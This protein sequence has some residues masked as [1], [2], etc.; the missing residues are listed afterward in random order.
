MNRSAWDEFD[1]STDPTVMWDCLE[2]NIMLVL[3][4]V[5][6]IRQMT[7]PEYKPDWLSNDIVQL[8]RRRDKMYREARRKKD[9]I[10]WRKAT[11]LRNRVEMEIKIYKRK[12]IKD[13]L[14]QNRHN[15]K[16]FWENI[17]SKGTNVQGLKSEDEV[18]MFYEGGDLDEHINDYFV[19]IGEK[20][21]R[22]IT[23]MNSAELSSSLALGPV[24]IHNDEIGNNLITSDEIISILKYVKIEKS[25]AIS[26]I[27]TKVLVHAFRR[28]IDRVTKMYN[29]SLTQCTFPDKWKK[30]IIVPLAKVTN[31]KTASDMR[32][33]SLL[34]FPGKIMEILVSKRLKSYLEL[35]NILSDKQHGFRKK[36]STLSAIVE[37]LHGV[38]DHHNEA[39][40]TYVIYLDLKKAFDTVSHQILLNKLKTIGLQQKS[41]LWFKNYLENRTQITT[42]NNVSS[43]EKRVSYGVPQGSVLGPTLFIIYINDLSDLI[44]S[45]INL[46]ADDTIVYG[47]NPLLVQSDME[48]VYN[49]CNTNLLTINCKK[50]QWMK[51]TLRAKSQNNALFFL[52][53]EKLEEVAEYKYLGVLIDSQLTFQA[54]GD[55]LINRVN[56]KVNYFRKIRTYMTLDSAILLYKCTIL[57]VLEYADFVHDFN[58]KYISKK[59]QTIQ[60]SSLYIVFNQYWLAHDLKDS[61]ETIHRR[62]SIYRLIHRIWMHMLLFVYNYSKNP[63]LLDNRDINTR[64]RDGILFDIPVINHYKA[65]QDP[66]H[67]A[68]NAWNSLPVHIRNAETKEKLKVL[69]M[70]SIN[71]P[72]EKTE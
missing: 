47:N 12:K 10:L 48:K 26:N 6:P 44:R 65:R 9:A 39:K 59:L 20:L 5:C 1:D 11:F 23:Q 35:H 71:N 45:K 32:P 55:N 63:E 19:G 30:A 56:L 60:N 17:N 46:Y 43:T 27:Q 22:K 13:E 72:Y 14:Q 29:G 34:P 50:S 16:R 41:I 31:P 51:I 54:Y 8:M 68:M 28:Q 58:I 49:W 69:L 53:N 64:R 67:R 3:N 66:M 70:N 18:G 25:S 42:I 33:I 62:A 4:E 57:P 52:G 21:A 7:V 15:P 24:N 61:T 40:D 38:Y 36:R 2:T 37:F